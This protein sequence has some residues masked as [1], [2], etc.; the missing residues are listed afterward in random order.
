MG[1]L[2][3]K[4]PNP[5]TWWAL[6]GDDGHGGDTFAAPVLID[7]R[8]EDRQETFY[9]ALDRRELV[10]KAVVHVDR[11]MAVGDYLVL[12]NQTGQSNPTSVA[13]AMKIQRYD[14]VPNLRNLDA[15]RRVVL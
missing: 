8:W 15:V 6:S 12:G 11:D 7:T 4:L 3:G 5:A 1:I 2:Q 14:K 9:G 10:S 13:G